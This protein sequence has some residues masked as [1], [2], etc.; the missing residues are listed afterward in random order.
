MRKSRFSEEQI[1]LA[2][3]QGEGGTPVDEIC[4]K[5]G[6]SEATL[7]R[8]K[9][10]YAG[11]GVTELTPTPS[12]STPR[13]D[14]SAFHSTG[15]GTSQTPGRSSR[16]GRRSTTTSGPTAVWG[17]KRRP[18]TGPDK[19][20]SRTESKPEHSQSYLAKNGVRT[21]GLRTD[22]LCVERRQNGPLWCE[23]ERAF[24]LEDRHRDSMR[25]ALLLVA[26][27]RYG[28]IVKFAT[29]VSTTALMAE[30][31]MPT[32]PVASRPRLARV[33]E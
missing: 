31:M 28:V 16:G 27:R 3:R 17:L 23:P 24:F 6:V 26:L 10:K 5:L 8:W 15:F 12:H 21:Q 4:R 9:K 11:L 7:F 33:A 14:E 22:G 25:C 30:A 20:R 18:S 2:L 32:S 1:A 19:P 13:S 29:L